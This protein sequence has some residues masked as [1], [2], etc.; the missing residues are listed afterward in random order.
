[1]FNTISSRS[2]PLFL[3]EREK[4]AT[5]FIISLLQ[6][7]PNPAY[8]ESNFGSLLKTGPLAAEGLKPP[9]Y[10]SEPLQRQS[11]VAVWRWGGPP[12]HPLS[13]S[14]HHSQHLLR[15]FSTHHSA[16][17]PP[18]K[19]NMVSGGN[20]RTKQKCCFYSY[21]I[22]F[23]YIF[24][25]NLTYHLLRFSLFIAQFLRFKTLNSILLQLSVSL[26]FS[27]YFSSPH[28]DVSEK[29]RELWNI[30]FFYLFLSFSSFFVQNLHFIY[31]IPH[32]YHYQYKPC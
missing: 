23:F 20:M 12:T 25:L 30:L 5:S 31:L 24:I 14:L 27:S 26:H 13:H 2:L 16:L 6:C 4:Q 11:F 17:Q 10:L 3:L 7:K 15:N 8:P 9:V 18:R 29:H 21:I 1:M 22:I 28:F 19:E 32:L